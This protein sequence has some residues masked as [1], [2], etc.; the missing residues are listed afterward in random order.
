M[1]HVNLLPKER[2]AALVTRTRAR[3]WLLGGT[4]YAAIIVFGGL[5]F[6]LSG[7][8]AAVATDLF[9]RQERELADRQAR[10]T[11]LTARPL[12]R[13]FYPELAAI[14]QPLSTRRRMPLTA[15]GSTHSQNDYSTT[16]S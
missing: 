5:S 4:G 9:Q 7:P 13:Q 15:S 14:R 6:M 8:R 3:R 11:E 16:C 12:L 1:I 10:V 2:R